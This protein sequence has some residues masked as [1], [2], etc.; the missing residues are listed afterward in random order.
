M[1]VV[2]AIASLIVSSSPAFAAR[3]QIREVD[4]TAYPE[5]RI[6]V[7][8]EGSTPGPGDFTVRENGTPVKGARVLRLA[9]TERQVGVVLVIDV[10]GSMRANDKIAQ[11]RAAARQFIDQKEPNQLV[12]IVAFSDRPRVLVNFTGDQAPL[13]AA[14]D[15]LQA[16]GETALYDGVNVATVLLAE[17]PELQPNILV[18]SDGEDTVSTVSIDAAIGSVIS[19]KSVLHA[20]GLRG[21]D[22]DEASLKQLVGAS[23]GQYAETADPRR[24]AELFSQVQATLQNQFEIRYTSSAEGVFDV[25]VGVGGEVARASGEAGAVSRG[26][27]ARPEVVDSFDA[28]F[29]LGGN[30]GLVLV[31]LFVLVAAGFLAAGL[32]LLGVRERTNLEKSLGYLEGA[33]EDPDEPEESTR[34]TETVFVQRAVAAV[35]AMAARRGVIEALS[36]RLEQ[37]DLPL[38]AGEAFFFYVMGVLASGL[39]AVVIAGPLAAFIVLVIVGLLPPALLNSIAARR[40]AKFNSQLPDSL[41][42]LAGSLRAGYSVMQGLEAVADETDDPM[43]KEFKRIV[44]ESR[45]GRPVDQALDEAAARMGSKDFDW[46]VMAIRIQREVGGNLAELLDTVA[47]TMLSRERLRREVK[48]LTAEGRMSAIVLGILPPGLGVY[49]YTSNRDYVQPLFE[50]TVGQMLVAGSVTLAIAGFLWMKKIVEVEI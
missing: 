47:D 41:Q 38:R 35:E 15:Q 36:R 2:A 7:A 44:V 3:V 33:P 26:A 20:V 19:S 5:V 45:L 25:S 13:A 18:L 8:V 17:R 12:A 43:S 39:A 49:I 11:A 6:A 27:T 4:T 50:T 10:S 46:A 42:L 16:S 21:G 22:F 9:E 30:T 48:A 34:F 24:L 29:F 23:G 28:P 31:G 32:I 14:I 1:A 37:A 40:K